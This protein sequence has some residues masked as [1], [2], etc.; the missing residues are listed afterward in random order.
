M[1]FLYEADEI[2]FAWIAEQFEK[3]D[4]DCGSRI[5][6]ALLNILRT[7]A[8]SEGLHWKYYVAGNNR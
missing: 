6:V 3:I 7:T 2:E 5:G 4:R 1:R 8:R